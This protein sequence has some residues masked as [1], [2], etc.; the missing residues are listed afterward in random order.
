MRNL[1]FRQTDPNFMTQQQHNF[2]LP[3]T[4][5]PNQLILPY[6]PVLQSP[7]YSYPY[8]PAQ[9]IPNIVQSPPI[10]RNQPSPVD[11]SVPTYRY[12]NTVTSPPSLPSMQ[13]WIH[14]LSNN[15]GM[16]GDYNASYNTFP[17]AVDPNVE[18][19]I[20]GQYPYAR[21]LSFSVIGLADLTI[22]T[23]P[24]YKLIPDPESTNPFLHG[25]DWN[26][27][28]RN[29]TL[30]IRFTAPPE[31]S[32]H[33]VPGA[34]N[35]IVYVGT[36][37]NGVPNTHGTIELRIY[38][39]SIGYDHTGGVGFPKIMY[40]PVPQDK[41]YS[42]NVEQTNQTTIDNPSKPKN[43]SIQN[44]WYF[45]SPK[46][47]R[48]EKCDIS[49]RTLSRASALIQYDYNDG[50]ILSDELQR[51]PSKLLFLRW[52][53]PT[54]PDTY[55]NIGILGNE[56][57]R[58]WSMS[59]VS[60]VGLLGLYTLSDFETVIDKNGYVNLV[61]S[62]G[63]PRP[64]CVTTESGFNW[65]DASNLPLIPLQLFYRN[66]IVSDDFPYSAK[67]VPEGDIVSPEVMGEYYPC[68]KYVDPIYFKKNYCD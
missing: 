66:K 56:D 55:H 26:A 35:N 53:A 30:K 61:I 40:V 57:M 45:S 24:D 39:P 1:Y 3:Y 34:G 52:K 14:Q 64:S 31:G 49:W 48:G 44:E 22:A 4:S 62:F 11:P 19:V 29:Y 20:K 8:V 60:P 43:N 41:R 12:Q 65:I 27:K 59:F 6:S 47:N 51:D 38:V 28:N 23:I 10:S 32:D 13:N 9:F 33:F 42:K 21:Y 37:P 25:A 16:L 5:Q 7:T 36:M 50:Y 2:Y 67:D 68:G 18:I 46:K 15:L 58:Y 54:F 63:A 17:Y